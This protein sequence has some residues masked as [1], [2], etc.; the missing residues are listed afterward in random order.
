MTKGSTVTAKK[1]S[2]VYA[3][4]PWHY[5]DKAS[6]GKRGVAYKYPVLSDS[7][8]AGLDV[9]SICADDCA[10]F[11][12]ATKPKLETA[13]WVL[14]RWGFLYRTGAFDWVKLTK[15]GNPKMGMGNWS[16]ANVEHVLLGI[17]GKPKRVSASVHSVVMSIPRG[18]SRKPDEVRD[19]IAEL[20]GDVPRIE[21]FARESASGWDSLGF[22]VGTGDI[23]EILRKSERR[24]R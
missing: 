3:D 19:R 23:R 16:R 17:R 11:L 10:L 14:R 21:L 5:R 2:V 18:H 7:E 4:P 9:A 1:Y 15:E 8:I 24:D 20:M 12:W 6:A 22:E 13:L